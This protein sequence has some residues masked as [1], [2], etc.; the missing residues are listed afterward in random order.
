M[1]PN[2]YHVRCE[3]SAA[4]G[5][6]ICTSKKIFNAIQGI[7]CDKDANKT[8]IRLCFLTP[9]PAPV[10]QHEASFSLEPVTRR[11]FAGMAS[12]LAAIGRMSR[13]ALVMRQ[14]GATYA[15]GYA[16]HKSM[17]EPQQPLRLT[18]SVPIDTKLGTVSPYEAD[19]LYDN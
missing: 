17:R 1:E 8:T 10:G 6:I 7:S 18:A 5:Q 15:E 13:Y 14:G 2:I 19:N 3:E 12:R 4:I 11:F 16:Y 9:N